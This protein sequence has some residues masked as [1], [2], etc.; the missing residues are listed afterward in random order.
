MKT[1]L[2]ELYEAIKHDNK[3][4][5]LASIVVYINNKGF[6]ILSKNEFIKI[7]ESDIFA[8]QAYY[9]YVVEILEEYTYCIDINIII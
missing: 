9:S 1:S 3:Y 6:M 8:Y 7:V 4:K 2:F 5:S